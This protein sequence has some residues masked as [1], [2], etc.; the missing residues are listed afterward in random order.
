MP[1]PQPRWITETQPGHSE[2]YIERFRTMAAEGADLVGEARLIDAM[3]PRGS[4]ILDAGCGPGR[5]GGYLHEVGHRAVGVD[6]DPALIA[7]A[8]QD[9]PGPTWLV[10][11]LAELDL[12]ARGITEP[13]D[14][15]VCAGNVMVFLAPGTE[16]LVLQRLAA[17]LADDGVLVVGF[18]T[19]RDLALADFDAA[20][21]EAGLRLDL[22]LS[23]WD[24]RPWHDGADFAVS[25]L[26][27]A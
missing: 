23:T 3:V 11:D 26:R 12:A 16:A 2:W 19:N 10:G 1:T 25:I 22:R 6:V 20:V 14:A 18:H 8:E 4:R 21:A 17:H 13:F 7:A 5:I 27:K 9:H 15:I 24:V